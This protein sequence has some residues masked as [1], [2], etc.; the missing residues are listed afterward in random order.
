MPS[1]LAKTGRLIN[2]EE[3]VTRVSAAMVLHAQTNLS[4]LTGTPK[5]LAVSTLLKPMR[6]ELSM[7]SLVASDAAVLAAVGM[8]D[9]VV[10]DL[11]ALPDSAIKSVVAAKWGLVSAKFPLDPTPTVNVL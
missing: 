4:T 11:T 3:F 7:I 10:V 8:T 2:T 9:N 5:N 1:D 6:P